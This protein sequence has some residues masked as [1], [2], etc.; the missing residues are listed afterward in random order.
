M[1]ITL[2]GQGFEN[3][4]EN[5]VGKH[6]IKMLAEK[7]Y[8]TFIGISAFSTQAAIKGLSTHISKAKK[9]LKTIQIITGVDQKV[10]SKEA[11]EEL[12]KLEIDA[13]VF[14]H[15]S[16]T[17]FHPKIYLFEGE[18]K[19][20]L[21]IG[22]SNLTSQGLFKNIETSILV[23]IDNSIEED[24]KIVFELK[25]YFKGIFD[26]SDPN[27]Q[28]LSQEIISDLVNAKVVP[29]E[30]ERK[31]LQAKF[32]KTEKEEV[33]ESFSKKFP[34]RSIPGIPREFKGKSTPKEKSE[35]EPIEPSII[36]SNQTQLLWT[37]GPLTERDLNIPKGKN[38]NPTGSMNF[39]KGK[40][41]GIDQKTYFR[42]EVFADLIW[43]KIGHLEK[44]TVFMKLIIDNSNYGNFEFKLSHDPRTNTASY[45][46]NNSMTS[47]S[48]GDVKKHIAKD[49]YIGKSASLFVNEITREFIL[50]IK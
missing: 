33:D 39:K 17:I 11:L 10:T 50:V 37:S 15:P 3:E 47:V 20:T 44:T 38:T 2:L 43:E 24:R 28:K 45:K 36:K 22:S 31:A 19:S 1:T 48:W 32:D 23:N 6:L 7:D 9:H 16:K 12:L 30:A 4:S 25:E 40:T 42:N 35:S 46:Q 13:F 21:I 27:L 26:F 49:E 14:Y 29:T 41:L 5:S 34:K 18:A 8:N